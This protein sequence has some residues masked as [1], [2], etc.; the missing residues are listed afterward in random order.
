[1]SRRALLLFDGDCSLCAEAARRLAAWDRGG[2]LE[3]RDLRRCELPA[4]D[5]RLSLEGCAARLHL[6]EADGRLRA[7]FPAVRRLT[8]LLPGLWWAAPFFYAPG[9]R[10]VL[11]PA[12]EL[13]Q[14]IRF[15]LSGP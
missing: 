10:L 2:R 3:L 14:R 11:E 4:L 6:L 1:M 5:P 8:T 13:L 9:A 12:Y 7:G 15:R